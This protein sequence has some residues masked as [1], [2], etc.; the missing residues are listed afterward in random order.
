[1]PTERRPSRLLDLLDDDAVDDVDDVLAAVHDGLDKVVNLLDRQLV[2]GRLSPANKVASLGQADRPPRPRYAG[3]RSTWRSASAAF[4]SIA[5][6][7]G[8]A[9]RIAVAART[10]QSAMPCISGVKPTP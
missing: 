5:P 10:A 8:M 9:S 3:P 7:S 1:M 6:S 2:A 4:W